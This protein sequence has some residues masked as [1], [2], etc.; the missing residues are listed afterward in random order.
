MPVLLT[1][2]RIQGCGAGPRR[3]TVAVGEPGHVTEVGQDAGSDDGSDAVKVHQ[4]A[5]AGQHDGLEL[6]GGLLD[7]RFD[8][9]QFGELFG[10]DATSGLPGDVARSDSREQGL[11]L[12]GGEVAF[13]LSWQEF[14]EQCLESVDGLDPSGERLRGGR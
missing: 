2:G 4:P 5:A 7:R 9:D 12:A 13:R 11:G 10:G 6:G 1:R 3:E 8:C 14:C